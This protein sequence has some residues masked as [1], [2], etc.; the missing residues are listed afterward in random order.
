MTI[1]PHLGSFTPLTRALIRSCRRLS[2]GWN[3]ISNCT[4]V[5]FTTA[6]AFF[7][8]VRHLRSDSVRSRPR[9]VFPGDSALDLRVRGQLR[10]L[11]L[12]PN[13]QPIQGCA[14]VKSLCNSSAFF[15]LYPRQI[16][17]LGIYWLPRSWTPPAERRDHVERSEVT[18]VL[19][20]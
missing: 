18:G 12:R 20:N 7:A 17:S 2:W 11:L 13:S 5:Y 15:W 10:Y 8:A 14:I 16:F 1:A 6:D 9:S 3:G 19:L 4:F